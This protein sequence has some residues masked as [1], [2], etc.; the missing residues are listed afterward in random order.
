M[1]ETV[2]KAFKRAIIV[3]LEIDSCV[4]KKCEFVCT[5][6]DLVSEGF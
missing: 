2:Y 3:E 6:S 5:A 4:A 1:F